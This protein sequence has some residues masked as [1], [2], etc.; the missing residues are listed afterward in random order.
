MLKGAGINP[1]F[2][3]TDPSA[4]DGWSVKVSRSKTHPWGIVW[5]GRLVHN[6]KAVSLVGNSRDSAITLD[7]LDGQSLGDW[8][9]SVTVFRAAAMRAWPEIADEVEAVDR[10]VD[11][12][13]LVAP[14]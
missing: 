6:G 11:I 5:S 7:P 12:L 8:F 10:A 3:P 2:F 1:D 9:A 14:L 13:S 4:L